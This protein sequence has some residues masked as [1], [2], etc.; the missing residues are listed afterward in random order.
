MIGA[1]KPKNYLTSFSLSAVFNADPVGKAF[2]RCQLVHNTSQ[3]VGCRFAALDMG[4][5]NVCFALR[6]ST[7]A[8]CHQITIFVLD[9]RLGI[10]V[11]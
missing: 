10:T 9:A 5:L 1:L 8:R 2:V 4:R 11:Q 6:R 7:M 3:Y